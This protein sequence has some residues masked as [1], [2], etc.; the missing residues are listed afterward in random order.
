MADRMIAHVTALTGGGADSLDNISGA[1]R[2]DG[3]PLQDKDAALAMVAGAL[4]AYLYDAASVAAE[5]S[6]DVIKPDDV[7]VGDPGRWLLQGASISASVIASIITGTGAETPLDADEIPFYKIVG[8]ILK[9]VTWS[10]IKAALKTYFDT[11]YNNYAHPTGD[12][13]LHVPANGT[14]NSGKV[15]TAGAA[16]GTYTWEES[17][18][19]GHTI[20]DEGSNLTARAALNFVGAGVTVTDDEGNG[21][22]K[23][24]IAGGSGG[25]GGDFL[26]MQVFS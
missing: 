24:T 4:S 1:D 7:A 8:T 16:A 26:V 20:Q 25:G 5:S 12:G 2:G 14:T 19:G 22:T 21:A 3:D 6:P 17:A 11:L 15:L 9:K 23:V 13:N 10:N 18:S